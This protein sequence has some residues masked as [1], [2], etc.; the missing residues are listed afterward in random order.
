MG[1]ERVE[2]GRLA[3]SGPTGNQDVLL[4]R[5]GVREL[6]SQDFC[7]RAPVDEL[8]EAVPTCELSNGQRRAGH[9]ARWEHG[10]DA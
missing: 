10:G 4:G 9:G 8:V 5:D 7:D 2:Q 3:G 6:R 1:R